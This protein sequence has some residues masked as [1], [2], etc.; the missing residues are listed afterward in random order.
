MYLERRTSYFAKETENL[1]QVGLA[2]T[3]KMILDKAR[4]SDVVTAW[5]TG[6]S[7]SLFLAVL[8]LR[9]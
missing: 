2:G 4:P 1:C 7:F 5:G 6:G 3:L 8:F 9:L